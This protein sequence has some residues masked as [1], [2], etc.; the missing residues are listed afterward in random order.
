M[1]KQQP[2]NWG[3]DPLTAYL[4]TFRNNQFATL[5][6]KPSIVNPLILVDG[7]YL[8]FLEGA[9]NLRPFL[10]AVFF[11][12]AH[13]AY[14]A[15]AGAVMAGQVYEAHTLLRLCLEHTAYG[16]FINDN[17]PRWKRWM[18]RQDS[19][20]SKDLVR[21][22][23]SF[24]NLKSHFRSISEPI[25]A[26]FEILYEKLIDFGAHPNEQGFSLN[27]AIRK[28]EN[29]DVHFDT[30]YLQENGLSL[31]FGLKSATEVGVWSLHAAQLIY[32]VRFELLGIREE[33]TSL[34]K[35]SW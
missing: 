9:T 28:Q 30:I 6:N 33:L 34:R 29:G 31:D 13:S 32:P 5:A 14:R 26:K 23:F 20:Q 8:R 2:P 18:E 4:E 1:T 17:E 16:V 3:T 21:K 7:L 25:G 35:N 11:L 24:G 19:K 22:E 15:A 10:P 12:R 27:S